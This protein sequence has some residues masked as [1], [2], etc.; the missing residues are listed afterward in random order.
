M[1]S[2]SSIPAPGLTTAWRA[3]RSL[4]RYG[5]IFSALEALH[6]ELGDIFRLPLPGFD[7]VVVVG[8]EAN[9]LLLTESRHTFLWRAEQDPVTRLLRQG[10]LVTDG[11]F[12][13]ELRQVMTPALHRS[14]FERFVGVM[15]NNADRV[16]YQWPARG[17][18]KLLDEMRRISLYI[19]TDALFADDFALQVDGLWHDILR[20][21][22][23]ISPGSWLLW[24]GIPRPGYRRALDHMDEY[25]YRLIA[26][27]RAYPVTEPDLLSGLIQS[28]MNDDL[29]RDQL[30]TMFIAGHDTSTALLA[31]TLCLLVSHPDALARVVAEVDKVLGSSPPAYGQV[32]ELTYLE[33]AIKEALRL[34]PPIHLGSRIAA[35]DIIVHGKRIPAGTRVI[36]SI[37]LTHHDKRYWPSPEIFDPDRFLPENGV[38]RSAYTYLPFGGGPRNCLGAAF[39]QTEAKIVLARLLQQFE[40]GYAG[41]TVRPRM[42]ATLE[43][44][45]GMLVTVRR[46]Q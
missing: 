43:P 42:R 22:R 13:D 25:F 14:L 39:A 32:R 40:F 46:R 11:V 24:P 28:G 37:Y 12:H 33:G 35:T 5:H 2:V 41:R 21:I 36:Y 16:S 34:Y 29:I 8:P 15:W 38:P 30:I 17:Q 19:L 3:V 10:V 6:D 4:I 31:W 9:K 26:A 44:D 23:Y 27:R 1:P 18:L 20:T 7:S 45:P